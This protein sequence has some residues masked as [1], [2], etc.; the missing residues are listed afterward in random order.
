MEGHEHVR[1]CLRTTD[2]FQ[3]ATEG[4]LVQFHYVKSELNQEAPTSGHG[5]TGWSCRATVADLGLCM[6]LQDAMFSAITEK[7]NKM[8]TLEE[9]AHGNNKEKQ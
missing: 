7:Q 6:V 2:P 1:T 5:P 3:E 9:Y 8:P 4:P